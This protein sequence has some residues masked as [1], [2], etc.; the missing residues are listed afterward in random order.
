MKNVLCSY[1]GKCKMPVKDER[2]MCVTQS[3]AARIPPDFPLECCSH[4]CHLTETSV[5]SMNTR[6][7][8]EKN[9]REEKICKICG[10]EMRVNNAV[11]I[12]LVAVAYTEN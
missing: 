6:F 11:S 2:M 9:M 10:I 4:S 5:F 8:T 1:N 12:L 7:R 3:N